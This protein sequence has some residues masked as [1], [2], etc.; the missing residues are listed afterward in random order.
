MNNL[1]WARRLFLLFLCSLFACVA[2]APGAGLPRWYK[3]NTHTHTLWSDGDGAPELSTDWYKSHGYHFLVLSDHNLLLEGEKWKRIGAAK[4]DMKPATLQPLIDRF[5]KDAVV[6]RERQ[7]ATE[8]RLKTL[9]ELR[10]GFEEHGRFLLIPGEEIS[11]EFQK[12]PLHHNALNLASHIPPTGGNS[13]R[14]VLARTVAAV[15]AE[16][17]R[18]GRATLA[19]LN[20]PN[21]HWAVTAEDIAAV[22][23]ERYFEVYNGHRGVR[24]HGDAA[25]RGTE[26]IWDHVL[27]LRLAQPGGSALYALATDDAH[28]YHEAAAVAAPGRGWIQ[29]RAAELTAEALLRALHAGDFYASSGVRLEDVAPSRDRLAIRIAGEPGVTYRTRF[30]GTKRG[31]PEG[32]VFAEV[33]GLEPSYAFAGDELYVRATVLSSRRHPNGYDPGDF[34]SAWVQPAIPGRRN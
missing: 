29:V 3:G 28:H 24:N 27:T 17:R 14:D 4:G 32:A 5:G 15:E 8:M 9:S 21:F 23:G 16:G 33:E 34:E 22:P 20:H 2:A 1:D 6:L 7:G 31:G 10:R 25:H 12:L 11:D 26:A 18:S 19:H 30:I 13:V